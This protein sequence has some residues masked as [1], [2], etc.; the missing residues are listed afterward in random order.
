MTS[1]TVKPVPLVILAAGRGQR[2]GSLTAAVPKCLIDVGGR[3]LLVRQLE[4]A[5]RVSGLGPVVLVTGFAR[6]VVMSR[7]GR[8]VVEC[9]NARWDS[10]NNIVSLAAAADAGWLDGG[11]VL[12]NSDVIFHPVILDR[13]L[14]FPKPC[15][16]AVDDRRALGDEEMKVAADAGGRIRAIAKTLDPAASRGEYIGLAKFGPQGAAA[17]ERALGELIGAGRVDDWYEAAF[18]AVFDRLPVYAC[19]TEG[20]PWTEVDTPADLEEARNLASRVEVDHV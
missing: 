10:A 14:A 2:L 15:A 20:L 1:S 12:F 11:F 9:H 5:G 13:L 4:A 8:G 3:S 17:V 19:S 6:D 18:Q 7:C 16:L